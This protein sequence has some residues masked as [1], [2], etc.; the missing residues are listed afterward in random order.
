MLEKVK[1]W[2]GSVSFLGVG[3]KNNGCICRQAKQPQVEE[4]HKNSR[5]KSL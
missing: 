4:S 2:K 1:G 3:V 5:R